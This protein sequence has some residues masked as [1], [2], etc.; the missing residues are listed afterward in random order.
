MTSGLL[1]LRTNW[2]APCVSTSLC[3]M[4]STRCKR[5]DVATSRA[6][7]FPRDLVHNRQL[8]QKRAFEAAVAEK[9]IGPDVTWMRGLH[10]ND[11]AACRLPLACVLAD[12]QS[13][14]LLEPMHVLLIHMLAA[15]PEQRPPPAGTH[16]GD[17]PGPTRERAR[18]SLRY[19]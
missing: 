5:N 14:L 17:A 12:L 15:T 1:S 13:C 19:R 2:E 9:V 4:A 18:S 10:R 7:L 3:R 11:P 6:Q 16:S 8:L